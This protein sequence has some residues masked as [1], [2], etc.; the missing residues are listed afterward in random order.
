M[1][2]GTNSGSGWWM[3][4]GTVMG[5]RTDSP[6]SAASIFLSSWVILLEAVQHTQ[7]KCQRY[8]E[9]HSVQF[10]WKSPCGVYILLASRCWARSVHFILY[11]GFLCPETSIIERTVSYSFCIFQVLQYWLDKLYSR[12]WL[13]FHLVAFFISVCCVL[14]KRLTLVFIYPRFYKRQ[15]LTRWSVLES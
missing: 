10:C 3:C 11:T 15:L 6:L 12:L 4:P 5:G 13:I 9:A 7:T 8:K 14:C 1:G 2:R